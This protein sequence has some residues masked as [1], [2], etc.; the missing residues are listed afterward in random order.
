ML[1]LLGKL[2]VIVLVTALFT[3]GIY[4]LVQNSAAGAVGVF[5][6]RGFENGDGS[7]QPSQNS[8]PGGGNQQFQG[9]RSPE[10]YRD[11]R[12]EGGFSFLRGIA[13]LIGH[14]LQIALVTVLVL[15]VRRVVQSR[16]LARTG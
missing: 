4:F 7:H 8:A 15:F 11:G 5:A 16:N 9:R 6:E 2:L 10:G 3:V 13:G 12:G 1:K 14:G